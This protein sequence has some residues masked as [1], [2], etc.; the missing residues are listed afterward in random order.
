MAAAIYTATLPEENTDIEETII[1][2]IIGPNDSN[3][4]L[5]PDVVEVTDIEMGIYFTADKEY[6]HITDD[7]YFFHKASKFLS[8]YHVSFLHYSAKQNI[9][10][11]CE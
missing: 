3:E 5:F 4:T 7:Y 11:S 2:E 10:H 8:R 1:E 6:L 9:R